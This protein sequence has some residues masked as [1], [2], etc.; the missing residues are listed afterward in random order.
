MIYLLKIA[1]KFNSILLQGI[2]LTTTYWRIKK[3]CYQGIFSWKCIIL[4][5]LS[6]FTKN[7]ISLPN[8]I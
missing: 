8:W 1:H 4:G 6:N 3:Y 7:D 5:K 2:K